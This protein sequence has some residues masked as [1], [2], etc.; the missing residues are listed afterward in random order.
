MITNFKIFENESEIDNTDLVKF[1][2]DDGKIYKVDS[3]NHSYND[4]T[5]HLLFEYPLP[6]HGIGV[7]WWKAEDLRKLTEVEKA[8]LI[9]NL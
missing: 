1:V 8:T 3:T 4:G 7:G 5:E 9:Y 6:S 2:I